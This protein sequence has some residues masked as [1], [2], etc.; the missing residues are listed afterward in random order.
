MQSFDHHAARARHE[1]RLARSLAALAAREA[2]APR[3]GRLPAQCPLSVLV[4]WISS[5]R[6]HLAPPGVAP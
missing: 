6:A 1:E 2:A 5:G 4:T 3:S